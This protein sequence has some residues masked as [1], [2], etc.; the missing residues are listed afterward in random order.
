MIRRYREGDID[1]INQ[2]SCDDIGMDKQAA[3]ISAS[4][5]YTI[6]LDVDG[7][8]VAVGGIV[9]LYDGVGQI[10]AVISDDARS[11][12]LELVR[13]CRRL[14]ES[15]TVLEKLDRIHCLVCADNVENQRFIKLLGFR[16]EFLM[17]KGG[18]YGRN[19]YMFSRVVEE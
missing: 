1:R 5:G 16:C 6:T 13:S 3:E 19:A 8:P 2:R 7:A 9:K 11:H 17:R 10:W 14:I 15:V 4:S 12:G 18:G